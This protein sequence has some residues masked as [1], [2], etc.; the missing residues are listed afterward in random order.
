[1]LALNDDPDQNTLHLSGATIKI[2]GAGLHSNGGIH[3]S[4]GGQDIYVDTDQPI[5]YGEDGTPNISDK[6]EAPE[7][8]GTA[9]PV[10]GEDFYIFADFAPDGFIYQEVEANDPTMIHIIDGNLEE[11]DVTDADGN[12]IDGL[13]IVQNGDVQSQQRRPT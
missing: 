10:S 4:G 3:V 6:M 9:P 1:M 2:Q 5:E 7:R 13:Y 8:I 12:Y 11:N